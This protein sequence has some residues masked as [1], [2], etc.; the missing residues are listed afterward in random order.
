MLQNSEIPDREICSKIGRFCRN[1][2]ISR[3]PSRKLSGSIH[4]W[5]ESIVIPEES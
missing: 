2:E 3:L 5:Y 4:D 1:R